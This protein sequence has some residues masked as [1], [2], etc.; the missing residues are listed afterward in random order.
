MYTN[1]WNLSKVSYIERDCENITKLRILKWGNY[2]GFRYNIITRV[3]IEE[4]RRLSIRKG[5]ATL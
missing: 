1:S 3:L 4:G 2:L 5:D